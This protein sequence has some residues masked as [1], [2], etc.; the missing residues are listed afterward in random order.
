MRTGLSIAALV[1]AAALPAAAQTP[2]RP[3]DPMPPVIS[4]AS[5]ANLRTV[6][7]DAKDDAAA[8]IPA[9]T[10]PKSDLGCSVLDRKA[11]TGV[12][13]FVALNGR[14]YECLSLQGTAICH[15]TVAGSATAA[16]VR[17]APAAPPQGKPKR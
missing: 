17:P 5:L 12:A 3:A 1:L 9:I 11:V 15:W 7:R 6:L 10:D 4:C 2:P 16:P 14:A 13:D 8:A